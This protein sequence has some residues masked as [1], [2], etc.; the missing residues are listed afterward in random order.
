MKAQKETVKMTFKNWL[1][2]F[3]EEKDLQP[4][5]WE[6]EHN[7][8]LHI[9]ESEHIIEVIKTASKEEQKKIKN[10]LV[11]ID[12]KNGNVNHFLNH[13]AVGYIKTNF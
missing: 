7:G 1:K 6:I 4:Q 3:L 13:L 11:M 10:T 8:T 2:T 9:V 5:T 12:F